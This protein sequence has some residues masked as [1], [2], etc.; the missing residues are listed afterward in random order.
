MQRGRDAEVAAKLQQPQVKDVSDQQWHLS[1][2]RNIDP[3]YLA[4]FLFIPGGADGLMIRRQGR[5]VVSYEPSYN[6]FE[7]NGN[8]SNPIN[9]TGRKTFGTFVP[10]IDVSVSVIVRD[11][12]GRILF[13][14]QMKK[15]PT[16]A[17]AFLRLTKH[18]I[19][20]LP[21]S[22]RQGR[23]SE[24]VAKMLPLVAFMSKK[25]SRKRSKKNCDIEALGYNL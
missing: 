11:A 16:Q 6:H 24:F 15:E 1:V 4:P 3:V 21:K 12:E 20:N 17:T 14:V 7:S 2:V 19:Q 10:D 23:K 9:N 8:H 5:T 25:G 13:K 22:T 18:T